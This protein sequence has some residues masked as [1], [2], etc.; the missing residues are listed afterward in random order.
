VGSPHFAT[1]NSDVNSRTVNRFPWQPFDG[2][3]GDDGSA[4]VDCVST[5]VSSFTDRRARA[6]TSVTVP[7]PK[8]QLNQV[9]ALNWM[10]LL[11]RYFYFCVENG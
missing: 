8:I 6:S 2:S 10:T 4:Q 7:A 3:I 1:G 5:A 11:S 9:A